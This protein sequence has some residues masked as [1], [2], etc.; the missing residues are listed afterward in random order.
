VR[1]LA[2]GAWRA[3]ARADP[4]YGKAGVLVLPPQEY[5]TPLR[6]TVDKLVG[7]P[8]KWVGGV[9]VWDLHGRAHG[10]PDHYAS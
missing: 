1:P 2:D 4:A 8:G 3:R 6:E 10:R 9:W 7:R 5:R